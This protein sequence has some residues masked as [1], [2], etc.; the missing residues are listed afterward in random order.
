VGPK[1]DQNLGRKTPARTYQN[2]LD[3][4]HDEA[5][6]D[7]YL[8]SQVVHLTLDGK[9]RELHEPA[10][11]DWFNPSPDGKWLLVKAVH[12][13]YSYH[14]P[15]SRFPAKLTV[16][17]LE[18]LHAVEIEDLPLADDVPIAFSSVRKGRRSVSWRADKPATL[19][20]VEAL[21]EGDAAREADFRD[22]VSTLEAPFDGEPTELWKT[23]L[24]FGGV[25]WGDEGL[26]MG[27]EWWYA[28]RRYRV[29]VLD[30]SKPG[31]ETHVAWDLSWQD[32][33][34]DP[35]DPVLSMGPFGW[36]V[37]HRDQ[38][39]RAYLAGD[40]YSPEGQFPFLDAWDPETGDTERV[41][42]AADPWLERF[43]DVLDDGRFITRRQSS[44]DPPNYTLRTPGKRKVV[45]VTNFEDWA[46][47][48]A[49][50]HKEVIRY[51][52]ADGLPLSATV[53]YP[54]G[55]DK[56]KDGP[57]PALFWAY[58]SEFK[59]RDDASQVIATSK[60]F[61]RPYASSHL[62][63][64][65]EGYLI[66]DDPNIPIIGEGDVQPND[67]YVEQLVSGAQ[68][69]VD[70]VVGMGIADPDKLIIGGHSYGAFTTANL[71]AHSDLFRAGI[72][73]SG[74]YNRSLTPWGFQG[75]E[76]SYWEGIDTYIEMSPFTHAGKIDEPLL[77]IHGADDS[78]SGTYPVQSER[79][80][81][82]LK[83]HG[84]T[85]RWVELPYEDHGYRA[86]ESVGHVLWEMLEWSNTWVK[87][88]GP[89]EA[90]V[91]EEAGE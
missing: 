27:T 4:A 43:V 58:P 82:A 80:F 12:R 21:D 18:S 81:E 7:Y 19:Y 62:F 73:R 2:L 42:Q 30:P 78:N 40:G 77:L 87:E 31:S 14:V 55:Y 57:L 70:A 41:W 91:A 89:R 22:A 65:L 45:Q 50:V 29:H 44:D 83:G 74:A 6:F 5:L 49:D 15:A 17:D 37:I 56:K 9:T 52:R 39:G 69:A 10:L 60:S 13:P 75:E 46:P 38:D 33:Y 84:A 68:A 79:F 76:R 1:V 11:I 66:V 51:E 61:D 72:A 28:D 53:Y 3:N 54:P 67:T 88:A 71:L 63:M 48:F 35:G 90:A 34:A 64:L 24:R 59:S 25:T 20:L 85:V 32:R 47:A 36:G 16:F 8:T 86:R 23:E 26:A